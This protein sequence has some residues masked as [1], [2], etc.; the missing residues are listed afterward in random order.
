MY[1]I[2]PRY[3]VVV[4]GLEKNM[5]FSKMGVIDFISAR[6]PEPQTTNHKPQQGSKLG[7]GVGV[8]P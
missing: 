7:F 8:Q 2:T 6:N 4:I 5:V 3:V 1:T